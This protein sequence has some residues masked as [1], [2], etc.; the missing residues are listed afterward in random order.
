MLLSGAHPSAENLS[1]VDLCCAQLIISDY[2]EYVYALQQFAV[3]EREGG[4]WKL[5]IFLVPA[6]VRLFEPFTIR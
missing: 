1:E 6:D 4:E 5:V 2:P 3:F